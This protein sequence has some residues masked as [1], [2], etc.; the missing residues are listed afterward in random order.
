LEGFLFTCGPDHLGHRHPIAGRSDGAAYPLHGSASGHP[1]KVLW[2][3]F[4]AGNAECRADIDLT[5]AEGLPQRIERLWRIDGA[6]GEVELQDRVVN[7]SDRTV[8]TFLMYHINTGGKW[9]DEGTRLEGDMIE[10]GSLPWLFGEGDG[11]IFWS[12]TP[13]GADG[14]AE[15]RLG[16][17]AAIN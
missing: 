16:P 7:T 9:L 4:E 3:R 6:T 11:G 13:A 14:F 15:V 8:P 10:G 17:I 12:P 1:A 5:T 2:T